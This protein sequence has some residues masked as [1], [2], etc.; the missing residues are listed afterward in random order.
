MYLVLRPTSSLGTHLH[1]RRW[2]RLGDPGSSWELLGRGSDTKADTEK[3]WSRV[4]TQ[5]QLCLVLHRGKAEPGEGIASFRLLA[6]PR[7]G[8]TGNYSP[9]KAVLSLNCWPEA[10]LRL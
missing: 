6:A 8:V 5:E 7:H 3:E 10:C 1:P 2:A 9:G 4:S